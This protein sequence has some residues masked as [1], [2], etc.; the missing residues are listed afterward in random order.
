MEIFWLG[1]PRSVRLDLVS[2]N[3]KPIQAN[4]E[5]KVGVHVLWTTLKTTAELALDG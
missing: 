2:R 1:Y 4:G 3:T 5:D